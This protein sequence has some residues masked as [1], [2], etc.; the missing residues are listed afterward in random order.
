M[1]TFGPAILPLF[2]IILFVGMFYARATGKLRFTWQRG[3]DS[4]EHHVASDWQG[5]H[6][7]SY[8]VILH[9]DDHTP[10][11]HVVKAL[12]KVIPQMNLRRAVSILYE[13]HTKGEAVVTRCTRE[14]TAL[15][16]KDLKAEG[17]T[18]PIESG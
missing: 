7:A 3:T 2:A 6:I 12:R 1:L 4:E 13:A 14:R 10:M 9:N 16:R 18:S 8:K 17:L 11:E 5:R 15:Y